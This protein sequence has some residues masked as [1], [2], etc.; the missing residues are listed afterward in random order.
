MIMYILPRKTTNYVRLFKV[1]D[2]MGRAY[3]QLVWTLLLNY[4]WP[5]VLVEYICKKK[6][7]EEKHICYSVRMY[8]IAS[9]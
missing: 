6:K 4:H 3:A 5:N 9:S 1:V 8:S 2:W 7:N